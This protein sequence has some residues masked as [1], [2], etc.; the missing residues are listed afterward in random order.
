VHESESEWESLARNIRACIVPVS[1]HIRSAFQISVIYVH[2]LISERV[3]I[4]LLICFS[5]PWSMLA[6]NW[7]RENKPASPTQ[8]GAPALTKVNIMSASQ[9]ASSSEAMSPFYP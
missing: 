8:A 2:W 5:M 1:T 3:V 6:F 4:L 7:L 9:T